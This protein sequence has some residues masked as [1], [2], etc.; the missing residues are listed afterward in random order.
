MGSVKTFH[1]A[2]PPDLPIAYPRALFPLD[3]KDV[4]FIDGSVKQITD[5]E[6]LN[7]LKNTVIIEA[8]RLIVPASKDFESKLMKIIGNTDNKSQD[9]NSLNL[10]L[11]DETVDEI[12]RLVQIYQDFEIHTLPMTFGYLG[13]TNSLITRNRAIKVVDVNE[14][15]IDYK[16]NPRP[17]TE[18]VNIL[19]KIE[20]TPRLRNDGDLDVGINIFDTMDYEKIVI[21]G[22]Y[23][24]YNPVTKHLARDVSSIL[25]ADKTI[26]YSCGKTGN[27]F[28]FFL[29]EVLDF[30]DL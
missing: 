22:K 25:S 7:I 18:D 10:T 2:S 21:K 8:R 15:D 3:N 1:S 13:Q 26:L 4:L 19:T 14:K 20:I 17:I 12:I 5:K 6:F 30:H 27:K 24:F 23:I 29:F 11:N 9:V 28:Q 16:G